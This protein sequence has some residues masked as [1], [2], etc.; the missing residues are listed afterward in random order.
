MLSRRPHR[1]D[2]LRTIIRR[3]SRRPSPDGRT[4]PAAPAAA[5]A[6]A[7]TDMSDDDLDQVAGGRNVEWEEDLCSLRDPTDRTSR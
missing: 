3:A 5:P 4:A 6:G 7:A 1:I 2:L